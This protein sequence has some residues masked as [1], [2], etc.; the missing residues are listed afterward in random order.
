MGR[1][2]N[3]G[4][5]NKFSWDGFNFLRGLFPQ[6]TKCLILHFFR[7]IHCQSATAVLMTWSLYKWMIGNILCIKIVIFFFST[8]NFVVI[9]Y[10]AIGNQYVRQGYCVGVVFWLLVW[11][12]LGEKYEAIQSIL[13]TR[14]IPVT[15]RPRDL[16][17]FKSGFLGPIAT[18]QGHACNPNGSTLPVFYSALPYLHTA[19]TIWHCH[20]LNTVG[21]LRV[22]T[23]A[24]V[25]S[26]PDMLDI[27]GAHQMYL[28]ILNTC[29]CVFSS[30]MQ[31]L[32][33]LTRDWTCVL[34]KHR[35]L[36]TR[37]PGKSPKYMCALTL[38]PE[39]HAILVCTWWLNL[40]LY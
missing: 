10:T 4:S 1:C 30:S 26:L 29:V 20:C 35:V 25:S 9:C 22:K 32:S 34:L 18:W 27:V 21:F 28:C 24:Y 8:C 3:P 40:D 33:Y 36:T 19:L 12:Q 11:V 37:P 13:M 15:L 14:K 39:V 2:K 31:N 6:S 38:S 17:L 23:T 7:G 5:Q 16:R